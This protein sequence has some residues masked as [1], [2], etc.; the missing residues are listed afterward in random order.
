MPGLYQAGD[1]DLAGFAVGAVER[2]ALLPRKD[3][4]AGRRRDRPRVVRRAFKRLFA[5][6]QH[7]RRLRGLRL[8]SARAVRAGADA[9][10]SAAHADAPLCAAR[11]SPRS[12]RRARSRRSPTSPAA[13]SL[14]TFRACCRTAWRRA[15]TSRACPS[16][17]FSSGSPRRA[18]SSE[19]EMLRTFNCGIGMVAVLDAN[20]AE[21]PSKRCIGAWRDRR[22]ARRSRRAADGRA[23]S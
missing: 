1:Y 2:D 7:R 4:A 14:K 9:R 11:A 18:A 12:A 23:A 3:I 5:R 20:D 6:A 13:A 10:R 8:G 19:H 17:R 15:S 21:Q 16:C 22:A